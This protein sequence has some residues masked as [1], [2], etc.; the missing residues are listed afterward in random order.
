MR[1]LTL[2]KLDGWT[3]SAKSNQHKPKSSTPRTCWSDDG[4]LVFVRT[5]LCGLGSSQ[6]GFTLARRVHCQHRPGKRYDDLS[7]DWSSELS[8]NKL[9]AQLQPPQIPAARDWLVRRVKP[10]KSC[11]KFTLNGLPSVK[12]FHQHSISKASNWC[13]VLP[14]L[15]R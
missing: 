3:F 10:A 7:I 11:S 13:Q 6:R 12:R 8:Q 1:D 15:K 9:N 2:C 4:T 14:A 5:G